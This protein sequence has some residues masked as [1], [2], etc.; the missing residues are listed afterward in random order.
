MHDIIIIICMI[1]RISQRN[2]NI[3]RNMFPC[4]NKNARHPVCCCCLTIN[5][6]DQARGQSEPQPQ[7]LG[8]MEGRRTENCVFW[9]RGKW[10]NHCKFPML[11]YMTLNAADV[12]WIEKFVFSNQFAFILIRGFPTFIKF[13]DSNSLQFHSSENKALENVI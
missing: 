10:A 7:Y 3:D 11:H 1:F 6:L 12:K 8:R 5:I 2:K 9:L 13:L 4:F